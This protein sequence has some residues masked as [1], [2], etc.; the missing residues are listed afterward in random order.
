MDHAV[1]MGGQVG[2][3]FILL[4]GCCCGMIP[5]VATVVVVAAIEWL[6]PLPFLNKGMFWTRGKDAMVGATEWC[7]SCIEW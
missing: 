1:R 4:F 2:V 7:S 3:K 5:A 6:M